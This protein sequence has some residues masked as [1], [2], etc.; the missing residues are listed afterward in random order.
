[1]SRF[2]DNLTVKRWSVQVLH[3]PITRGIMYYLISLMFLLS[4]CTGSIQFHVAG[5]LSDIVDE[6]EEVIGAT[7]PD[8]YIIHPPKNLTGPHERQAKEKSHRTH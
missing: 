4:S 3:V 5:T 6:A 2:P 8:N 1:M 7:A